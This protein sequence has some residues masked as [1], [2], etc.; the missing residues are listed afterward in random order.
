LPHL[1]LQIGAEEHPR[2]IK[3][4][5]AAAHPSRTNQLL[6]LLAT[7]RQT[8]IKQQHIQPLAFGHGF[9]AKNGTNSKEM[10]A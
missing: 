1:Q 8:T 2:L 4:L 10:G 6:S 3:D 9:K 5:I 7:R